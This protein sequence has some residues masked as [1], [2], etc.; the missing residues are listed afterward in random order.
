VSGPWLMWAFGPEFSE[1][2]YLLWYVAAAQVFSVGCGPLLMLM[3]MDGKGSH[4][5]TGQLAGLAANAAVGLM[6]IPSR[7]AEGAVIAMS[8]GIVTWSAIMLVMFQKRYGFNPS[9]FGRKD[10]NSN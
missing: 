2:A 1:S 7:G 8:I 5:L 10:C 4:A 3:L 6:L 9:L